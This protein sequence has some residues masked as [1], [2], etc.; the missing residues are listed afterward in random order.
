[1]IQEAQLHL[2]HAADCLEAAAHLAELGSVLASINRSYYAVF[3]AATACLHSIGIQR[4]SHRA[5]WSVFGRE[6][7]AKGLMTRVLHRGALSLLAARNEG[8]YLS[9]PRVSAEEAREHLTFAREFVAAARAFV[10]DHT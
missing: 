1:M 7:A 10:E 3:R 2:K 5:L 6:I 8:D 9:D 4:S